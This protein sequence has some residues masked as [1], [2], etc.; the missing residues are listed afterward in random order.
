MNKPVQ[1]VEI[2]DENFNNEDL[3]IGVYLEV[4]YLK[5]DILGINESIT[6]HVSTDWT[7]GKLM[8][9]KN[10]FLSTSYTDISPMEIDID[11][12][13]ETLGIES[14]NIKY[15]SWYFPEV[16]IKFVDIR[17][18][19]VFNPMERTNDP[20]AK[21]STGN[22]SLIEAFFMFPYPIFKLT[23]KGVYGAPVT[24]KLTVS[25]VRSA[26]NADNGNFE[27]NVKF[28]GY[29][30]GYMTDIPV[31]YLWIAPFINYATDSHLGYFSDDRRHRIPRF[32]ELSKELASVFEIINNSDNI[33]N[34]TAQIKSKEEEVD[35]LK[36][37]GKALQ[38]INSTLMNREYF[39][40]VE[41]IGDNNEKKCTF[42]DGESQ[43]DRNNDIVTSLNDYID[44]VKNLTNENCDLVVK[45]NG[46]L[47]TGET[48]IN[49][50]Y[51]DND[52]KIVDGIF[53]TA[54]EN[55][56]K[57]VQRKSD[58]ITNI[59]TDVLG[60]VPS[61]KNLFEMVFA[62]FHKFYENVANCCDRI[63]KNS[64]KR[65]LKYNTYRHDCRSN[66]SDITAY[67]FPAFYNSENEYLWLE[68]VTGTNVP[69][70]DEVELVNHI[71]NGTKMTVKEDVET[72]E[73]LD[74]VTKWINYPKTG[75]PTLVYDLIGNRNQYKTSNWYNDIK[76]VDGSIPIVFKTFLKRLV[77]RKFIGTYGMGVDDESFGKIEALNL[78]GSGGNLSKYFDDEF[79]KGSNIDIRNKKIEEYVNNFITGFMDNYRDGY[80]KD[81]VVDA[82]TYNDNGKTESTREKNTFLIKTDYEGYKTLIGKS[83]V[84]LAR[85]EVINYNNI[86]P[87]DASEAM[88]YMRSIGVRASMKIPEGNN[89]YGFL[90]L[91]EIKKE[92]DINQPFFPYGN[93][94]FIYNPTNFSVENKVNTT[95]II[96]K[97][98]FSEFF[99]EEDNFKDVIDLMPIK[100]HNDDKF[101]SFSCYN[102]PE[103]TGLT[104]SNKIVKD[105]LNSLGFFDDISVDLEGDNSSYYGIYRTPYLIDVFNN[106][107]LYE[108]GKTISE[109]EKE[110]I[111]NLANDLYNV[112]INKGEGE[113]EVTYS[114]TYKKLDS[115]QKDYIKKLFLKENV[116]KVKDYTILGYN[117]ISNSDS[118]KVTYS[119]ISTIVEAFFVTIHDNLSKTEA[120]VVEH[121]DIDKEKSDKLQVYQTLKD[122]YDRWKFGKDNELITIDN[123]LFRDTFNNDVGYKEFVDP[124][125]LVD[126]MKTV[127]SGQ[128]QINFY[129][130]L[131]EIC[132]KAGFQMTALPVNVYEAFK[133]EEALRNV[134]KP[135]RY[136]ATDGNS[137]QTTYVATFSHRPS[138]HLNFTTNRSEYPDD[139]VDFK[140]DIIE[141]SKNKDG[142][143]KINVFGI[144]YGLGTQKIFRNISV[145]MD[146]PIVTEQSIMSTFNISEMGASGGTTFKGIRP[147]NT[148]DIY[149]NHS[150]TCKVEMMG[151]AQLMPLMYFQLNNIPMFKGGYWIINVEHNITRG[152][153]KTT[154]T[155]QR[156]NK[157]QFNLDYIS[158]INSS[159]V[160]DTN[161]DIV[162]TD[163]G[164]NSGSNVDNKTN[165]SVNKNGKYSKDRTK[166]FIVPGHWMSKSGKESPD[167]NPEIFNGVKPETNKLSPSDNYQEGI[168]Y[169]DGNMPSHNMPN[170]LEPYD[171]NGDE[172]FRYREYWGNIKIAVD[173]E[174]MLKDRGYDAMVLGAIDRKKQQDIDPNRQDIQTASA[175]INSYYNNNGGEGSCIVINIHSN[176]ASNV[177]DKWSNGNRWEIYCK[178]GN[179]TDNNYVNESNLLAEC[180]AK[181]VSEYL[182]GN[183]F[184]PVVNGKAMTVEDKPKT[185]GKRYPEIGDML[186]TPPAVLSEN[187][188]HDTK[189][190]V[191]FLGTRKGREILV[192]AHVDGIEKFF[193]NF[194]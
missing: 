76:S 163:K 8:M 147:V 71:I 29:M 61:I 146:K 148:F 139:S 60:W 97:G 68:D 78:L 105:F 128:K 30:Y 185:F 31:Q 132:S 125:V 115:E 161:E 133:N 73:I 113:I 36:K 1:F 192:N 159:L 46:E 50:Y 89:R 121:I 119:D 143:S 45:K 19:S 34:L 24:Y 179:A 96:D 194:E 120:S 23:V 168:T 33:T 93:E 188:F 66:T 102:F 114:C 62:H 72:T 52:I 7:D 53:K 16:D 103:P 122:L 57:L 85:R 12:N 84:E 91:N 135:Q 123:F 22:N 47:P 183:D 108:K 160:N 189:E 172:V 101:I 94:D 87:S 106:I 39:D 174:K 59:Y 153:M 118:N 95:N 49:I 187:L 64:S 165:K 169:W 144:T 190:H 182:S 79:W 18:N 27:I 155:G 109:N 20:N 38:H 126:I 180:I 131:N 186:V 98:Y 25:N 2:N 35:N 40:K 166:I 51:S 112:I 136:F 4:E 175:F 6:A 191:R 13:I 86:F 80:L 69:Q 14:I 158:S 167:L 170:V 176:A 42:K 164:T 41:N 21:T 10:G 37:V 81:V 54:V 173:I 65:N 48:S 149:S 152:N 55:Y 26:F 141:K 28:I 177:E 129:S 92:V 67:P 124:M 140:N 142:N 117:K 137:M 104:E 9:G 145:S 82:F 162:S 44:T 88:P 90:K 134:F 178:G 32:S 116:I 157:H 107:H 75:I 100:R 15:T 154:F 99:W 5:R 74:N 11:G 184:N 110:E 43:M 130:L 70:Y 138:Q 77:L 127:Q 150:Y 171:I 111:I 83:N 17:G 193:G 56:K 156:L 58:E 181:S 3:N 63:E 151:C